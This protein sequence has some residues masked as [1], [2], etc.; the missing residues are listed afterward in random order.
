MSSLH[1]LS[2]ILEEKW[3]NVSTI[4][5]NIQD[6]WPEVWN[7]KYDSYPYCS[8]VVERNKEMER[9]RERGRGMKSGSVHPSGDLIFMIPSISVDEACIKM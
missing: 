5:F 3:A 4:L 9:E 8:S 6:I 1:R 2:E 7:R